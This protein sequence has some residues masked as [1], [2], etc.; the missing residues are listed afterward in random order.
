[1]GLSSMCAQKA[2]SQQ[3]ASTALKISRN[4]TLFGAQNQWEGQTWKEFVLHPETKLSTLSCKFKTMCHS[5]FTGVSCSSIRKYFCQLQI[6][7]D[8]SCKWRKLCFAFNVSSAWSNCSLY[9]NTWPTVLAATQIEEDKGL[10]LKSTNLWNMR[11]ER[12]QQHS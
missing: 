2:E 5:W 4:T 6:S 11:N 1:M 12:I 3:T 8:Y 9:P 7:S 10:S